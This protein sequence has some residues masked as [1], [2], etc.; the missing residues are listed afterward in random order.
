M[1][2][3]EANGKTFIGIIIRVSKFAIR[4]KA[5]AGGIYVKYKFGILTVDATTVRVK[6]KASDPTQYRHCSGSILHCLG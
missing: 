2:H 5:V 4:V 6:C 1:V 3:G